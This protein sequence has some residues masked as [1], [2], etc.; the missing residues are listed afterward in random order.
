MTWLNLPYATPGK[1]WA[2]HAAD[3]LQT[4]ELFKILP[5]FGV[6]FAAVGKIW[7]KW[8]KLA[9]KFKRI[10]K[11]IAIYFALRATRSIA[12]RDL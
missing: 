10:R 3:I 9:P 2:K 5:A 6:K 11:M 4:S 1:I 12:C 7:R 8:A